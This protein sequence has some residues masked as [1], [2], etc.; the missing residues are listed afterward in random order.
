MTHAAA[1][2]PQGPLFSK[3][4]RRKAESV[5]Q[6]R[7]A[8]LDLVEKLNDAPA[9]NEKREALA[10]AIARVG[11]VEKELQAARLAVD[12]KRREG[13]EASRAIQA[14]KGITTEFVSD[15][16]SAGRQRAKGRG[17]ALS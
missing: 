10:L 16:D 17:P 13:W 7:R 14:A 3:G 8:H 5:I 9:R 1:P 12:K 4:A 15:Y 11:E 2:N 6:K